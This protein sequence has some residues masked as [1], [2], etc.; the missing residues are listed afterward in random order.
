MFVRAAI[1]DF[2]IETG[3]IGEEIKPQWTIEPVW[4]DYTP[5]HPTASWVRMTFRG[6][7]LAQMALPAPAHS[8][9]SCDHSAA[10]PNRLR[11]P[12]LSS[13]GNREAKLSK[14]CYHAKSCDFCKYCLTEL[15]NMKEE[16]WQKHYY[17]TAMLVVVSNRCEWL[18]VSCLQT[19]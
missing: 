14:W 9:F 13:S 10:K 5:P 19:L 17:S 4:P 6:N 2:N 3:N 18:T 15:L 11:A 1:R 12:V 7:P 16:N 8:L